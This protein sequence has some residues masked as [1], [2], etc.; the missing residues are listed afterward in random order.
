MRKHDLASVEFDNDQRARWV[1]SCGARGIFVGTL[2]VEKMLESGQ[3]VQVPFA[4]AEER[5]R[6]AHHYHATSAWRDA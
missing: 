4:L 6:G 3:K 2:A 5:A 1:C